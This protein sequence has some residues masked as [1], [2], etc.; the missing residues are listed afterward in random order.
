M[1]NLGYKFNLVNNRL[2]GVGKVKSKTYELV[3]QNNKTINM[4]S[5]KTMIDNLEEEAL[6][7]GKRIKILATG[8]S[9]IGNNICLKG[10]DESTEEMFERN[11]DYFNG[12]VKD[13][14]K[15]ENF[16]KC[17]IHILYLN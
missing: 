10:F 9:A 11:E 1:N 8:V 2:D 17:G 5:L 7:K 12:N 4:K 6:K 3:K 13:P 16:Y 14:S 15:F